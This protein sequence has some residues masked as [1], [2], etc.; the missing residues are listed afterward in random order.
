MSKPSLLLRSS[1]TGLL[2]LAVSLPAN[3]YIPDRMFGYDTDIPLTAQTS[4]ESSLQPG[5]SEPMAT[6]LLPVGTALDIVLTSFICVHLSSDLTSRA[7]EGAEEK[8]VAARDDAAM[9]LATDGDHLAVHLQAALEH[10]RRFREFDGYTTRDLAELILVV[11][12]SAAGAD[13]V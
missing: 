10:L 11:T 13:G 9:Y 7:F 4:I 2:A 5:G 1:L 12:T 8:I 6:F 3:A